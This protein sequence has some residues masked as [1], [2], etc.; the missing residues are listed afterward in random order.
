MEAFTADHSTL[1]L[2]SGPIA[3]VVDLL[4]DGSLAR[5][6]RDELLD[7]LEMLLRAAGCKM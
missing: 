3:E 4:R 5:W 1:L 6:E 2:H 7:T